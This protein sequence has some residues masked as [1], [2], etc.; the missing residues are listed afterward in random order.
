[1]QLI[2]IIVPVYNE[3]TYLPRCIESVLSQGYSTIE[4]LLIDDGSTDSSGAICDKYAAQDDRIRVFHKE[5]EG[6]SKTRNLGISKASGEWVLFL[7]SDDY[8]LEDALLTLITQAQKTGTLVS[9]ANL[10]IEKQGCREIFCTGLTN[11]II[12]NNFR[13]WYFKSIC[14][15]QG[16]TLF[17]HSVITDQMYDEKLSRGEDVHCIFKLMRTHKLSYTNRCVMV[18]SLEDHGLSARCRDPYKDHV[19]HMDFEGKSFWEKMEMGATLNGAFDLYPE[20]H[21]E[22]LAKY[23]DYMIYTWLDCKIR[24]FKKYKRNLYNLL[25]S[26]K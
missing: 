13:A 7:D 17:H 3:E 19:F 22:L 5:N 16:A 18:Y 4:L 21:D 14:L 8:L 6:V 1:M 25:N 20:F 12:A 26:S 15:C 24:R 10:Y 11:G 9:C 2:S 23:E